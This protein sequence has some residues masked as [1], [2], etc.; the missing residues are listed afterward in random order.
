M[1]TGFIFDARME[2]DDYRR[3]TSHWS[4]ARTKIV[5]ACTWHLTPYIPK[6]FRIS[7]RTSAEW[8]NE[9]ITC[10]SRG[11]VIRREMGQ[12]LDLALQEKRTPWGCESGV[13]NDYPTHLRAL[14]NMRI[15]G[16]SSTERSGAQDIWTVRKTRSG[17]GMTMV[18]RPSGVVR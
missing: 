3:C 5:P 11:F 10:P 7:W 9:S 13:E 4:K 14:R 6:H 8:T 18:K 2:C 1:R 17:W 16:E 12:A 15:Q